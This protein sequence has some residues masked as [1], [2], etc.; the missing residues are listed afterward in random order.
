M[1]DTSAIVLTLLAYLVALLGI[2]LWASRRTRDEDD[3]YLG[4]RRLGVAYGVSL[5]LAALLI[6][7]QLGRC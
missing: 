5:A 4:G 1:T 2:G 7:A 3:F 6:V